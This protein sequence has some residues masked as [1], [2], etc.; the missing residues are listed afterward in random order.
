MPRTK[1]FDETEVLK[2]AMELFWEK[3]YHGTSY[4]D[5]VEYLSISRASLYQTFGDKDQLYRKALEYYRDTSQEWLKSLLRTSIS[6]REKLD[7]LLTSV[8]DETLNDQ[9]QKGC[10]MVN[11][12]TELANADPEIAAL[13]A[14]NRQTVEGFFH[15]AF[16]MAQQD[17]EIE[18]GQSAEA[19]AH[20]FFNNYLGL[21][22]MAKMRPER[23]HLEQIKDQILANFAWENGQRLKK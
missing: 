14:Q 1:Q 4:N 16:Y 21:R 3:G 9:C 18:G 2:R 20:F 5:L 8:I 10:F 22:V 23:P 11:S 17:G 13:V 19:L 15:A 7:I 6:L 12:T